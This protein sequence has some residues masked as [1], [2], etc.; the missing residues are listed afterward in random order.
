MSDLTLRVFGACVYI[1]ILFTL[2]VALILEII[3]VILS[4]RKVRR[5]CPFCGGKPEYF[6]EKLFGR[7]IRFVACTVCG[8][9]TATDE[10]SEEDAWEDWNRRK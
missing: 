9:K 10:E 7:Q 2:I 4:K 8:A 1:G 5:K 6:E 3:S